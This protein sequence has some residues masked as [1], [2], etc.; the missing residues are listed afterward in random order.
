MVAS[1]IVK[2]QFT[3]N[4]YGDGHPIEDVSDTMLDALFE[5]YQVVN[6]PEEGADT[7][8]RFP[9]LEPDGDRQGASA[10]SVSDEL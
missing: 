7:L 2:P 1:H 3:Y 9:D 6:T 8:N 5:A 10:E 4:G